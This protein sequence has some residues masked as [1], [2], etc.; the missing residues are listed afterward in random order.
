[1]VI[2]ATLA[3]LWS[4]KKKKKALPHTAYDQYRGWISC[5]PEGHP[6]LM[7]EASLCLDGYTQCCIKPPRLKDEI[8]H[9][10]TSVTLEP[11]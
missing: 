9:Q 3:Q 4:G 6:E 7:V 10:N 2:F 8:S 1:M 11:N 5:R